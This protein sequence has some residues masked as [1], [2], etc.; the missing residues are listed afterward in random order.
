MN[1]EF[2]NNDRQLY[3]NQIKG[4]IIEFNN[5]EKYCSLTLLVGKETTRHVNLNIKKQAFDKLFE[6]FKQGD[7]VIVYYYLVSRSKNE[8]WYTSANIIAVDNTI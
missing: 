1:K 6:K 3:F 2:N 5:G 7:K 4:N 8:K